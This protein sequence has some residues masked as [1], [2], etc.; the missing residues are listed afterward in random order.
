MD[1]DGLMVLIGFAWCRFAE[2]CTQLQVVDIGR[3]GLVGGGGGAA[4]RG[5]I[6]R[7]IPSELRGEQKSRWNSQEMRCDDLLLVWLGSCVARL[8]GM[9]L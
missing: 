2:W 4:T 9:R 5:N 8:R 7:D 6:R 3:S 1:F